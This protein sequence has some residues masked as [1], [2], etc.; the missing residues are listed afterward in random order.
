MDPRCWPW[1]HGVDHGST[2]NISSNQLFDHGFPVNLL[3]MWS[4]EEAWTISS[5]RDPCDPLKKN[6]L[7]YSDTCN[8]KIPDLWVCAR[9]F[10]N[11]KFWKFW[12]FENSENLKKKSKKKI[13]EQFGKKIFFFW[14]KIFSKIFRRSSWMK[15]DQKVGPAPRVILVELDLDNPF[16]DSVPLPCRVCFLYIKKTHL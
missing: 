15:T 7:H 3:M 9:F 2:V 14:T 16:K 1:I 5:I 11:L 4:S 12:N 8:T 10:P 6:T 13:I